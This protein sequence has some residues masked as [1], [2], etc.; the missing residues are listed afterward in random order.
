MGWASR[1]MSSAIC[2]TLGVWSGDLVSKG[3]SFNSSL[4]P[5]EKTPNKT[6]LRS[7]CD[8]L[9]IDF[10]GIGFWGHAQ[11]HGSLSEAFLELPKLRFLNL[12]GT[13]V[14]GD[15]AVLEK[16]NELTRLDLSGMNVTGDL[17]ALENAVGLGDLG[18]SQTKVAG[19]LEALKTATKLQFL[20]LSNAKVEGNIEALHMLTK[21]RSLH[22]SN[23]KVEGNIMALQK[24]TEL[25]V[26]Y[27]TNTT[28]EGNIGA[29]QKATKLEVLNLES[30]NIYGDMASLRELKSLVVVKITGTRITGRSCSPPLS[31]FFLFLFFVL[32]SPSGPTPCTGASRL[33]DHVPFES[34]S[35]Q[36]PNARATKRCYGRCCLGWA[37]RKMSS[38]ICTTSRVLSGDLVSKGGSFDSSVR[39]GKKL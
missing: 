23:T 30:T 37:S 38:A 17:K 12:K 28:V 33:S 26:L 14:S 21:L 39:P 9:V 2:V 5:C 19:D 24:A 7:G 32:S 34:S 16:C 18:L 11:L 15:L 22:L 35:C 8:V 4:R 36:A 13:E 29:L 25:R 1:K 3:G 10:E 20:E 27:L 31:A 6:L